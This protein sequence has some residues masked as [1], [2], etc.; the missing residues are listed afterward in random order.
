MATRN[1]QK[2]SQTR[3]FLIEDRAGPA[4]APQ[5]QQVARALGVS[6]AQGDLTPVR[7]PDPDAYGKFVTVELQ[8]GQQGLPSS[9]IESRLTRDASELLSLV[10]K[11]CSFDI[12]LHAGACEDPRDF[13]GG[14]EKIYNFE[15]ALATSYETTEMGALDSDQDVPVNE[16][17]PF[18]AL[19]YYEINRIQASEI[20]TSEIVQEIVDVTICDSASCGE[21]GI[22]SNGC[23]KIFAITKSAGGSPGLP[24]EVIY[25]PDAGATIG[26]T[27]VTSLAANE[28]PNG[29]ACVGQYLIVISEDSESIHYAPLVEILEGT[30]TWSEVTSGFVAGKGPLAI[31]SLSAVLTWIAAEG[32]YIYF[33]EDPTSSVAPLTSGG[34]TANDLKAIHGSDE[35]NIVAVGVSNT[36]LYSGDGGETWTLITGPNPG[37]DLNTVVVRSE[38]EWIVGAN[39]GTLWYTRDSGATWNS[40]GFPGSGSGVIRD[41]KFATPAVGYMAHSTGTAGRVLRTVDGGFSWYVLPERAG[42][43]IPANDYVAKL[44][45]CPEDPNVVFGGGLADNAVDGFLVKFA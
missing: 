16:S 44:T 20:A 41:I 5:Y 42:L 45:A 35:D 15:G 36:V 30:E 26:E 25:S 12:Q 32:G 28:D 14:W 31:F 2:A 9:T 29:L 7:I 11:G 1:L 27:I 43:T 6:W 17:L 39:D 38:N 10:R 22:T 18:S 33:T 23:E 21:C 19:D 34:V 4:N 3:L 37:V 24:A 13:N 8:R 40:K